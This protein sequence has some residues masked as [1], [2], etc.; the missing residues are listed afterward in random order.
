MEPT[1]IPLKGK[2]LTVGEGVSQQKAKTVNGNK[3]AGGKRPKRA[4]CR[5]AKRRNG[6][7]SLGRKAK[8]RC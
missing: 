4:S 6:F 2:Y 7:P 3:V 8:K 1:L 5:K